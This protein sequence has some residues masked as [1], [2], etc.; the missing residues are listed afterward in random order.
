MKYVVTVNKNISDELVQLLQP[1]EMI[2]SNR[3]KFPHCTEKY[4]PC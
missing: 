4:V 2:Q 1:V 3:C